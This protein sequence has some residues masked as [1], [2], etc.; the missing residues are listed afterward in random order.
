MTTICAAL[1]LARRTADYVL[2]ARTCHRRR[3][4][5]AAVLGGPGQAE[6]SCRRPRADGNPATYGAEAS[7]TR[8]EQRH[9]S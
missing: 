5:G 7:L 2:L 3:K 1:G 4:I 6:L 8:P 9:W